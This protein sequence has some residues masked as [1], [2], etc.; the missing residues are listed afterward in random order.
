MQEKIK[1]T[2]YTN[3]LLALLLYPIRDIKNKQERL[4]LIKLFCSY[5]NEFEDYSENKYVRKY[6]IN[7][8]K[9][10]VL[11]YIKENNYKK[12]NIEIRKK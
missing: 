4:N 3:Q 11:D 7:L 2:I 8:G 9:E 6:M 10:K 12:I 5:M 1:G